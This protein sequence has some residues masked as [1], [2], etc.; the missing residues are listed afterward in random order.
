MQAFNRMQSAAEGIPRQIA[1]ESIRSVVDSVRVAIQA[2][3]D[4]TELEEIKT[5]LDDLLP[6]VEE[7]VR[8]RLQP[9]LRRVIN[10]TGV[11]IHTNLGRSLL[12]PEALENIRAAAGTYSNLEF[13]LETGERG[14]RHAHVERLLRE[15]TGAEAAMVVNNN[16]GAV[17]LALT[18]HARGREVIVS[19]GQLIEIGGS[20]RLPEVMEQ[21]GA[22][23]VEVGATNRT[24][25]SDF[26]GAVSEETAMLMRAHPSNYRIVG[27]TEE[28]PLSEMS[29]LAQER[30]LILLD[31]LGSG[32]LIDLGKYGLPPEPTPAQS[33]SDGADLVTF[34]GDKLLGGPQ[35]GIVVGR[36]DLVRGMASHPLARA[37][38]SDKLTLAALEAVLRLYLDPDDVVERIPTLAML[39]LPPDEL[40]R[41]A[42]KLAKA[43]GAVSEA[44]EVEVA[45]DFSQ[46]GGGSLP[47][48]SIPTWVAS[49]ASR[50]L[51]ANQLE[52]R[53]RAG[54]P[55]I[56]VRISEDRVLLDPRTLAGDEYELVRL[57]FARIA[58]GIGE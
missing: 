18:A 44:F 49:V 37:L 11:V 5:G 13:D 46:A 27:F 35:A 20:F 45:E 38:R 39:T 31:D 21:S 4:E 17:L 48:T 33:L 42:R 10:A 41:R 50:R 22:R 14:S 52:E 25:I 32:V 54:D 2:A 57:A 1:V 12:P 28:T 29:A 9:H 15:L 51:T 3:R 53:L 47:A 30:G 36:S 6:L 24:R 8:E 43:I 40:K 19:R 26:R 34:S 56:I 23:L 58:A 7:E 55:P 16:A